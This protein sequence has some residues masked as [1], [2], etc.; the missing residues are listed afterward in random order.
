M[1]VAYASVVPLVPQL[2]TVLT[3]LRR[4]CMH[5]LD[6]PKSKSR[7]LGRSSVTVKSISPLVLLSLGS[8]AAYRLAGLI[9]DQT[10]GESKPVL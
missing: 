6:V 7:V 3:G 8:T 4:S 5:S 10:A 9:R 1:S 2:P